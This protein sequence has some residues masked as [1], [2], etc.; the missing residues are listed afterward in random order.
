MLLSKKATISAGIFLSSLYV[1]GD[2]AP[3]TYDQD[4]FRKD[5]SVYF[6]T[7]EYLCW[8]PNEGALDYAIKMDDPTWST[9]QNS[10][11]AGHY[12]NADFDWSSGLRFAFGYFR[13][14][15]FWDMFL[16]Y[17][18]VPSFG[19][20]EVHAPDGSDTFLNGTW[21]HPDIDTSS[22][23]LP[24]QHAHSRIKLDYHLLD[25][26]MSRRFH[27]NPHFRLNLIGGLASAFLYQHWHVFLEDTAGQETKI[28]NNWSF[29]GL[30]LRM[31]LKLD[32]YLGWDLYLTGLSTTGILSGWY[33]NEASQK[34]DAAIV[35]ADKHRPFR[36][37]HFSDTR[38]TYTAQFLGGLS[39][40]K[41]FAV[42]R[43][44]VLL[45]YEFNI[46]TNL[47]QVYRS[48]FAGA[49]AAKETYINSSNLSMQGLTV[50]W[51]I[52]F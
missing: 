27:T 47:H 2:T 44:E 26:L 6:I 1:Y 18:F 10:F 37:P 11:A 40:Q 15:H 16:Q 45:G 20:N 5:K 48:S 46:W 17:T 50:R 39:W 14:P 25:L 42:T 13:A 7:A 43:S 32:W 21:I 24:L 23:A 33:H 49:T 36:N 22:S 52:D 12:H 28:T 3:T 19:H 30:G 4:L 31:G 35:N 34:T 51:N 8:H 38:L 29:E 41:A 9:T